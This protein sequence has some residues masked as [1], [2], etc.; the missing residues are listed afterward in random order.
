MYIPGIT[1]AGSVPTGGGGKP[2]PEGEV[3]FMRQMRERELRKEEAAKV[4]ARTMQEM[5]EMIASA[6]SNPTDSTDEDSTAMKL[7]DAN[8]LMKKLE[9]FMVQ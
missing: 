8:A 3:N 5:R 7:V 1:T 2:V 9:E 6:A 4:V